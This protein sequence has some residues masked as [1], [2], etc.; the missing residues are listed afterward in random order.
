[1]LHPK[2]ELTEAQVRLALRKQ[3]TGEVEAGHERVHE[4][5]ATGFLASGLH[6]ESL[7]YVHV[8]SKPP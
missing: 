4:T 7:Q 2:G 8:A 6:I 5:S 1:M 3:E